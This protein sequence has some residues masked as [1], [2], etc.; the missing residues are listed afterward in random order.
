VTITNAGSGTLNVTS[1]ASDTSWLTIENAAGVAPPAG[2]ALLAG[3]A[4]LT[5]VL[6]VNRAGLPDGVHAATLTIVSDATVGSATTTISVKIRVGGPTSG[7]VGTV[8]VLALD[9]TT[10]KTVSEGQTTSAQ[11]YTFS[12]AGI[13]PGRYF[14]IAGTDRD[15]DDFICDIEDACGFF[16]T[17]VTIIA[18]QVISGITFVVGE[19]NSPQNANEAAKHLRGKTF[20]RRPHE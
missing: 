1:I 19:L 3:V 16:P 7:N 17:P 10:L 6:R 18:D 9:E 11:G 15:N 4:P 12:T 8:I 5:T 2:V 13:P 20:R 14:L